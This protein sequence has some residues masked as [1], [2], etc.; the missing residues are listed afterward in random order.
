MTSRLARR[1][2]LWGPV[3][4]YMALIF[5]V[6]AQHR[7][8]DVPG[9]F[10]DKQMHAAAYAG[11]SGLACRA[12]AGSLGAVSPSA[13][14]A[15]WGIA[16]AYGATD[17]LHQAFVP[18]RSSDVMDLVADSAGAAAAAAGLWAWGIIA[19]SRRERR[20]ARPTA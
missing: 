3:V 11:L 10:N 6:S 17:E 16:T 15:G 8:P 4:L 18:G 12:V 9:G 5:T 19:R 1:V 2:I 13:A 7:V 14:L 20:D